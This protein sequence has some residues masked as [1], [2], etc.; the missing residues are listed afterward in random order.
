MELDVGVDPEGLFEAGRQGV[1][2][3]LVAALVDGRIA[4]HPP[5]LVAAALEFNETL[6][7][8]RR[9]V[10]GERHED[11]ARTSPHRLR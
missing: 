1:A 10:R 7:A 3:Q 5:K 4:A 6:L 11:D 2:G 8:G 9:D